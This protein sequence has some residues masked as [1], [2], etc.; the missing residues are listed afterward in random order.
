MAEI[1]ADGVS[2]AAQN[3]TRLTD[4]NF[5]WRSPNLIALCSN[6]SE[7]LV[8]IT[9]AVSGQLPLG[10]GQLTVDGREPSSRAPW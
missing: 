1:I 6:D 5:E 3:G 10:E 8:T 7:L 9:A 2:L 4:A